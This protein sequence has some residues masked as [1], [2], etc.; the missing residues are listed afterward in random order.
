MFGNRPKGTI[1]DPMYVKDLGLP[2]VGGAAGKAGKAGKVTSLIKPILKVVLGGYVAWQIG[3]AIG[4][5]INEHLPDFLDEILTRLV[6]TLPE[7][8]HQRTSRVIRESKH[9]PEVTRMMKESNITPI[10]T[11]L[12]AAVEVY[13]KHFYG[14]IGKVFDNLTDSEEYFKQALVKHEALGGDFEKI[15]QQAAFSRQT[16]Q[17]FGLVPFFGEEKPKTELDQTL[18]KKSSE[19]DPRAFSDF[20]P[21]QLGLKYKKDKV[22]VTMPKPPEESWLRKKMLTESV[23][24]LETHGQKQLAATMEKA[25]TAANEDEKITVGEFRQVYR[26]IIDELRKNTEE[27]KT[28][29]VDNVSSRKGI[30]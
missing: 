26:I 13:E 2:G 11:K 18:A 30:C 22:A 29:T 8:I 28:K 24:S 19:M 1:T 27:T 20:T 16:G 12:A 17:P 7:N 4:N 3:Q 25:F 14:K 21:A 9:T 10:P 5:T 23:E 6:S 15:A